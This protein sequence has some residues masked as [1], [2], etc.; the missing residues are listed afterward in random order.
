MSLGRDGRKHTS[1]LFRKGS[2]AVSARGASAVLPSTLTRHVGLM[3]RHGH[4]VATR[5]SEALRP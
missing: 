4:M 1:I 5:P 3:S 2:L